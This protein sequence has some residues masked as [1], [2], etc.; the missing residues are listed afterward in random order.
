MKTIRT[1]FFLSDRTGITAETLGHSLLGQF[2]NTQFK[3]MS[4]PFIQSEDKARRAV[5]MIDQVAGEDGR[6]PLL[7]CTVVD[8][9]MTAILSKSQGLMLDIFGT[10]TTAIE[11]E[12]GERSS[13]VSGHGHGIA[14]IH[15][16][17][18]R[19]DAM[20]YALDNDDGVTAKGYD[21]ADVILV[22][23]SRCGK[24]PT[25]IYL[26][27]QYGLY[28]A[29]YPLVED[30]LNN[31]TLPDF[32]QPHR[33]KLYGLTIEPPRLRQ[34]RAERRPEGKYATQEQCEWEVKTAER[35]FKREQIRCVDTTHKSIEEISTTILSDT[36]VTRRFF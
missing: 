11:N 23:V 6:R 35:L 22:G 28:A 30:D 14:N 9:K 15:N 34:I 3:Y 36:G 29:N 2:P 8:D 18:Q 16:Y 31:L 25:C 26:A 19:I 21:K 5:D 27:L 12:L 4:V 20:H 10:F 13:T 17:H 24:T 33:K 1:A 7:F 32:L